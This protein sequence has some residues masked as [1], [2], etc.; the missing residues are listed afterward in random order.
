MKRAFLSLVALTLFAVVVAAQ[1]QPGFSG[2]A[3]VDKIF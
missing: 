3:A 1:E 2:R